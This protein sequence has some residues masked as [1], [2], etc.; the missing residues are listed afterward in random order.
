MWR[1]AESLLFS[2][3]FRSPT[4]AYVQGRTLDPT[5]TGLAIGDCDYCVSYF[6]V[7]VSDDRTGLDLDWTVEESVPDNRVHATPMGRASAP[8]RRYVQVQ[9]QVQGWVVSITAKC[10]Q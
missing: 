9:V 2:W 1:V 4:D 5:P 3:S 10:L 8:A 6:G 7:I